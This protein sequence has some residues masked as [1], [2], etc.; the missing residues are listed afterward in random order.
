MNGSMNSSEIL[1]FAL[2]LVLIGYSL[3]SFFLVWQRFDARERLKVV[4]E[5][6]REQT[7]HA[8][9]HSHNRCRLLLFIGLL[10]AVS[11]VVLSIFLSKEMPNPDYINTFVYP[12]VVILADLLILLG[13]RLK[14][15][16]YIATIDE[17][18]NANE[19]HVREAAAERARVRDQWRRDAPILN[20][21]ARAQIKEALGDNYEV[22]YQHDILEGRNVLANRE[23]GILYAQGVVL[24]FAE[25]MEVRMGRKDLKLV[26]SNS[27]HPFIT[28]DFGAL[29]INPET[30]NKYMDEIAEKVQ[31]IIP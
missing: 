6:T 26:T 28:I 30:G 8:I 25:I 27:L 12:G 11:Y 16:E 13:L 4:R 20:P 10:L 17:Y 24:P 21:Q 2:L 31:Q 29:P 19:E 18:V 3:V 15:K 22:W 7:M 1:L 23:S 5:V 14:A 9:R